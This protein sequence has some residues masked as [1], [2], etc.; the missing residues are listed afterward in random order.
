MLTM[1]DRTRLKLV[2]FALCAMGMV[3]VF[4]AGCRKDEKPEVP[5]SSPEV[6][7][8]DT[9]FLNQVDAKRKE[10]AAIVRE[11]APLV[12]RMEALVKAHGEDLA[13]LQ[14][15]DEWNDLH[16]K[17]VELNAKYEE[18]RARQLKIVGERI[19]PARSGKDSASPLRSGKDS[20]S[21]LGSGKDSGRA[22]PI[23]DAI[24]PFGKEI[25]K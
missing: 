24:A 2:P 22:S 18:V 19:A 21:P 4:F 7:M 13:A 14:K 16:K 11:R 10:L 6:Y 12:A 20:A 17:V 15:L 23:A 3:A 8:K 1:M 25:S 5:A 9:N